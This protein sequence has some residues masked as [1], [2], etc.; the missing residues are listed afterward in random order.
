MTNKDRVYKYISEK[1]LLNSSYSKGFTTQMIA[2]AFDMRRPN[3][4]SILNQLYKEKLLV[5]S[6]TR[7]VTYKPNDQ[8]V[9]DPF[10]KLI[11]YDKSLASAIKLAKAT[12]ALPNDIL[13]INLEVPKGCGARKFIQAFLAYAKH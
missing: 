3:A 2:E 7:P 5:K 9:D 10:S 1:Y 8:I 4:S 13:T 6:T 12:I 11:G